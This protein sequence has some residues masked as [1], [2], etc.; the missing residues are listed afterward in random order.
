VPRLDH[1]GSDERVRICFVT[2]PPSRVGGAIVL[3]FADL[4]DA[5]PTG[6]T[7][8]VVG[9]E[10]RSDFAGLVVAQ[11]ENESGVYLFYCDADWIEVT[12]TWHEDV[13]GAIAQATFEYGPL[14]FSTVDNQSDA[15]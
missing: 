10:V 5:V 1:C 8:H 7:K 9:G 13:E 3:Q 12:D 6:N 11:Y 4:R 2:S 15:L 14:E